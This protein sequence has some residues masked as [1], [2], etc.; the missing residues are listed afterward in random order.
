MIIGR[1][2]KKGQRDIR[3]LGDHPEAVPIVAGWIYEEW[4]M[5]YPGKTA[6]YIESLLRRRLNKNKLPMT[7]VAFRSGR[8]VGTVSLKAQ[9]MKIRTSLTP[10]VTS[11]YVVEQWRGRGIGGRL[12][13]AIEKQAARLGFPRLF[14]LTV[15]PDLVER[16]YV[17]R[18]WRIRERIPSESYEVII[19]EKDLG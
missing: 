16:F 12:M 1:S 17:R 4:S 3:F 6:K 10:W 8:P 7:L 18:S 14:L 9:D 19:M 11:L 2:E 15:D 13:K 5:L